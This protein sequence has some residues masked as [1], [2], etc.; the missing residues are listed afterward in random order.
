SPGP[1]LGLLGAGG[2]TARVWMWTAQQGGA[3]FLFQTAG[4]REPARGLSP[5]T[6]LGLGGS[7]LV[8]ALP[9][10]LWA[11]GRV[12]LRAIP[13]ILRGDLPAEELFLAAFSLIPA[14]VL[15]VVSLGAVVKPDWPF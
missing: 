7:Q 15:L 6:L 12:A 11:W 10:L 13:R 8:L 5:W 4:R 3:S 14:V 9:P 1:W 2:V